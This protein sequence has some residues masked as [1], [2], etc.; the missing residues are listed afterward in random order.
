MFQR[1]MEPA[2]FHPA[3]LDRLQATIED[4][5]ETLGPSVAME[6]QGALQYQ[7]AYVL[8]QNRPTSASLA[9]ARALAAGISTAD[10]DL[11]ASVERLRT[12]GSAMTEQAAANRP[13]FAVSRVNWSVNNE[14]PMICRGCYNPFAARQMSV[15]EAASILVKLRRHGAKGIMVSGGDPLLWSGLADFLRLAADHGFTVGLDTT[16]YT[17]D[18]RR[19]KEL[20]P[21]IASMGLPLDGSTD[22]VQRRFRINSDAQLRSKLLHA[23]DV[24]ERA[25]FHHVRVHTVVHRENLD[26]LPEIAHRLSQYSCVK[27]WALFEWWGRRAPTEMIARLGTDGGIPKEV[28]DRLQAICP[29]IEVLAYPAGGRREMAN[30][31]IQSSGQVVTFGSGQFEEFILGNLLVDEVEDL[32]M[33]PAVRQNALVRDLVGHG[34]KE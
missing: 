5:L 4:A 30:F 19:L 20:S 15:D 11:R 7:L 31:F 2:N 1:R 25:E 18:D 8:I 21:L 33:S 9:R 16:G 27:Q 14:C 34:F 28:V 13:E 6:T 12:I 32:V 22:A 24:C 23:L 26:D 10:A 17:L 29:E 3:Y